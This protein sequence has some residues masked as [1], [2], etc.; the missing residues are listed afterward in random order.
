MKIKNIMQLDNVWVLYFQKNLKN[1]IYFLKT[2][3]IKITIYLFRKESRKIKDFL[4]L[5]KKS[6]L[7]VQKLEEIINYKKLGFILKQDK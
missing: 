1:G 2:A 3:L 5:L 4:A 7:W 6:K